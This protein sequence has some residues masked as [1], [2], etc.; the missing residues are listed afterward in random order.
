MQGFREGDKVKAVILKI[1]QRRISLSLKPSLFDPEDFATDDEANDVQKS[2]PEPEQA[3]DDEVEQSDDEDDQDDG[4]KIDLDIQPYQLPAGSSAPPK[5]T[6][7]SLVVSGGF[8]WSAP[9]V[10]LSAGDEEDEPESEDEEAGAPS[11][12]KRKRKQIE[13]DLTADMH[14]KTPESNSDFERLLLGSPNSSYL[15]IQYMS[16]QLQISEVEKA[17]EVAHRGLKTIHFREEQERLNV[18]IALLNLEC[19]YGTDESLEKCFKDAAK[20]N[21]S[22]TVHLRLAAILDQADKHDVRFYFGLR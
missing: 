9:D 13:H 19:T 22:K 20:A 12:K 7:P 15:W 11:R 16:F 8:Q 4:M 1:E 14:T 5:S 3:Q 2:H 18:W 6:V 17:R 21:D 10:G